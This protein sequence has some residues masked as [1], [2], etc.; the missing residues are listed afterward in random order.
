MYNLSIYGGAGDGGDNEDGAKV[1]YVTR[2]LN[3]ELDGKGHVVV[4]DNYYTSEALAKNLNSRG[5]GFVGTYQTK[6]VSH[7]GFSRPELGTYAEGCQ[8]EGQTRYGIAIPPN[9]FRSASLPLGTIA[10][11]ENGACA[12]TTPPRGAA[13]N[14]TTT[15]QTERIGNRL[16][17]SGWS[18]SSKSNPV[19]FLSNFCEQ[20]AAT[21]MRQP[22][23]PSEENP[24]CLKEERVCPWIA[25]VYNAYYGGVDTGDMDVNLARFDHKSSVPWRSRSYHRVWWAMHGWAISNGWR[26]RR[27]HE[28]TEA[29]VNDWYHY[30]SGRVYYTPLRKHMKELVDELI[31]EAIEEGFCST[32]CKLGRP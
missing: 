2:L 15:P 12:S 10:D 25:T 19:H 28:A 23:A 18:D 16:Y 4:T 6:N 7:Q 29:E 14:A 3:P 13:V 1:D 11:D 8:K 31:E 17:V 21:C 22:K 30:P 9:T 32:R 27:V 5:I 26:L 24:E 20:E